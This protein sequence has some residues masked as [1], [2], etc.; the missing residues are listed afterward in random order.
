[1][2][3]LFLLVFS[4]SLQV[5]RNIL[6]CVPSSFF[7]L[8][9]NEKTEKISILSDLDFS[10]KKLSKC[11]IRNNFSVSYGITSTADLIISDKN[12]SIPQ[13]QQIIFVRKFYFQ[14]I[15]HYYVYTLSALFVAI[16]ALRTYFRYFKVIFSKIGEKYNYTVFFITKKGELLTPAH[17]VIYKKFNYVLELLKHTNKGDRAKTVQMQ[18]SRLTSHE[19]MCFLFPLKGHDFYFAVFLDFEIFDWKI[20]NPFDIK[21]AAIEYDDMPNI[22]FSPVLFEENGPYTDCVVEQERFKMRI[23]SQTNIVKNNRWGLMCYVISRIHLCLFQ[24]LT[25]LPPT[26]E[27]FLKFM[28]N[29]RYIFDYDS[30]GFYI[31]IGGL[32]KTSLYEDKGVYGNQLKE[33]SEAFA[34]KLYH[35]NISE[36]YFSEVIDKR[37]FFAY[38]LKTAN[39][40][41][42]AV[43]TIDIK[44]HVAW[45]AERNTPSIFYFAFIWY[46]LNM[47]SFE[48]RKSKQRLL[49]LINHNDKYGYFECISTQDQS[50]DNSEVSSSSFVS[51]SSSDNIRNDDELEFV[52]HKFPRIGSKD[53][54]KLEKIREESYMFVDKHDSIFPDIAARDELFLNA[55]NRMGKDETEKSVELIDGRYCTILSVESNFT[56][57][58]N[59]LTRQFYV[60]DSTEYELQQIQL[61]NTK[62]E[63]DL[64]Y[65]NLGMHK[66]LNP[67]TLMTPALSHSLG[68]K[69]D[70]TDLSELINPADKA[71]FQYAY[72]SPSSFRLRTAEGNNIWFSMICEED[73]FYGFTGYI[74]KSDN[75]SRV[76]T[77]P[78]SYDS[79]LFKVIGNIFGLW[80]IDITYGSILYQISLV[81]NIH[82]ARDLSLLLA[83][84]DRLVFF[85]ILK[86]M[87][88]QVQQHRIL[89]IKLTGTFQWYDVTFVMTA[90]KTVLVYAL[91]VNKETIANQEIDSIQEQV[92]LALYQTKISEW[93]LSSTDITKGDYILN[94][95]NLVWTDVCNGIRQEDLNI[96][97]EDVIYTLNTGQP[98]S[99]EIL[100][101]KKNQWLTVRGCVVDKH[102]HFIIGI[103]Y[104]STELMMIKQNLELQK[105]TALEASMAKSSFVAN[106]SHEIRAPLQGMFAVLELLTLSNMSEDVY[107]HVKSI[108]N[109]FTH[110]LDL[111]NNILDLAKLESK[112]M[113]PS[114]AT[115][116]LLSVLE[117]LLIASRNN[118]DDAPIHLIPDIPPEIP[119]MFYGD[120]HFLSRIMENFLSNAVK[121]TE[122][123]KIIVTA[124]ATEKSLSLTVS[125]TGIGI[126]K[127]K[128]DSL[129]NAFEGLSYEGTRQFGGSSVGLA[130][131]LNM[132]EL[133]GGKITVQSEVGK[134]SSFT[135]TFP[136]EAIQ[137][138]YF[139]KSCKNIK[140]QCFVAPPLENHA[141]DK[142]IEYY[143]LEKISDKEKA[144]DSLWF[145]MIQD[146]PEYIKTAK[147]LMKKCPNAETIIFTSKIE[148][149][150]EKLPEGMS[151]TP[152]LFLPTVASSHFY[153]GK[154]RKKQNKNSKRHNTAKQE[155]AKVLLADDNPTNQVVM[156][157]ILDK[158][159]CQHKCVGTGRQA[160]EALD[161]NTD[162]QF[163]I[164]IMDMRMPDMDGPTATRLIRNSDKPYKNVPIVAITASI[165]KEDEEMCLNA[166]MNAFLT[167]P[168]SMSRLSTVIKENTHKLK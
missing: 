56:N 122:K 65:T 105:Q 140:M 23:G 10:V 68:Y 107:I 87:T 54:F 112:R 106:M 138:R 152:L 115:F 60:Y 85:D 81:Q 79:P 82:T 155:L 116:N 89:K 141:F 73:D 16:F 41:Y 64:I 151:Y 83:E 48:D 9:K 149:Q 24:D 120:P 136:Y 62:K 19:N 14:K 150:R 133:V 92:N 93:F 32:V 94:P 166:G 21:N 110:L 99:R 161:Q 57:Y 15:I 95:M 167:K 36:N 121:F 135:V 88:E 126:T 30:L 114:Y 18:Y 74:Y 103:I 144:N 163:D 77:F 71:I 139:P 108:K 70:I 164:I 78:E 168:I 67:F 47:S 157:K 129:F 75:S 38:S 45:S 2:F 33:K 158:I 4:R 128:M 17:R 29:L 22:E 97:K 154:L 84:E 63:L 51:S 26:E 123:G 34:E 39:I 160:I 28:K 11:L 127:Q 159:G 35:G 1:M 143:G 91:D 145:I 137:Y 27:A 130:V 25:L 72:E 37:R 50:E 153:E 40:V 113:F 118:L 52:K 42:I 5:D 131:A 6:G 12:Q 132:A 76:L 53:L 147:E 109:S 90:P 69:E 125:D 58:S 8:A 162:N 96:L 101:R 100:Y 31:C 86:N 61:N 66:L 134:G 20:R 59:K 104:D 117:P 13:F 80:I 46:N 3:F 43:I 148:G 119:L 124:E 98:F 142:Y 55:F 111:L 102:S 165:L 49:N 44:Q 156:S 146:K 7:L